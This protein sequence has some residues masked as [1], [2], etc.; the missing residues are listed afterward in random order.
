MTLHSPLFILPFPEREKETG[1]NRIVCGL[2]LLPFVFISPSRFHSSCLIFETFFFLPILTS[3]S[4]PHSQTITLSL[5]L[6]PLPSVVLIRHR[7]WMKERGNMQCNCIGYPFDYRIL[8]SSDSR[9]HHFLF[10]SLP[11]ERT[12]SGVLKLSP[13]G[14]LTLLSLV[15]P[16]LVPCLHEFTNLQQWGRRFR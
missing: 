2:P 15:L 6:S 9:S 10:F 12:P 13:F 5:S 11:P 4:Q 14:F 16:S 1:V 7:I 3:L 8:L